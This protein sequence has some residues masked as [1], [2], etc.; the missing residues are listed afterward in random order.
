[1]LT[2]S[3]NVS[4]QIDVYEVIGNNNYS[5]EELADLVNCYPKG[6]QRILDLLVAIN[7]L[8]FEDGRYSNTEISLKY[9]TCLYNS[10][11]NDLFEYSMKSEFNAQ[12]VLNTISS[13]NNSV[14]TGKKNELEKYMDA[15]ASGSKYSAYKLARELKTKG[16]K[17]LLDV[18]CGPGIYSITLCKFN[19]SLKAEC[20][21][22]A[23]CLSITK[24]YIEESGLRDRVSTRVCDVSEE[25]FTD[26]KFYDYILLSNILHFFDVSDI[27]KVLNKC[28]SALNTGGKIIIND[29]FLQKENIET[30]F[31]SLEWLSN[32]TIF[33]SM[34]EMCDCLKEIGYAN[35]RIAKIEKT[36]S[37]F[38]FAERII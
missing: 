15:M 24:K 21:D 23:E 25:D 38:I 5:I 10:K 19:N 18:G 11:L 4:L 9:L 17:L 27:R 35:L 13:G 1:M 7:L 8:K 3:F 29:I 12:S 33:I 14:D 36:P 26:G 37:S 2:V 32:G 31:Y 28:Y 30:I 6:L 22:L 16:N 34:E 20:V